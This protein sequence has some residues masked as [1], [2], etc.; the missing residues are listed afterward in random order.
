MSQS[1]IVD[2]LESIGAKSKKRAVPSRVIKKVL[3]RSS[4]IAGTLKRLG[5]IGDLAFD[6]REDGRYFYWLKKGI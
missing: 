5:E 4:S 2:Y 6:L 3:D 1:E